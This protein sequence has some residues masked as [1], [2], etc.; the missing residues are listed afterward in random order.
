MSEFF[1]ELR[2]FIIDNST[3]EFAEISFKYKLRSGQAE[4]YK[5]VPQEVS[6]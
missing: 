1:E 5:F 2:K 6:A 3:N 4:E